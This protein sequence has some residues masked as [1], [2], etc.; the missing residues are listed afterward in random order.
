MNGVGGGGSFDHS[1]VQSPGD[2][3]DS[4][5]CM[6]QGREGQVSAILSLVH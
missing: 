5:R 2:I 1:K 4:N 3:H 6:E